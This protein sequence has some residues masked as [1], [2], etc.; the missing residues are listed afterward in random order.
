MHLGNF[1]AFIC[2]VILYYASRLL[3]YHS[4]EEFVSQARRSGAPQN[5]QCIDP[6]TSEIQAS[7]HMYE[8]GYSRRHSVPIKSNHHIVQRGGLQHVVLIGSPAV[9]QRHV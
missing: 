7:C 9:T 3:G 2:L 8:I 5:L 4:M 6:E 1:D